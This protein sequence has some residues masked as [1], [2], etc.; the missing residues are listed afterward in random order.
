MIQSLNH[1]FPPQYLENLTL[2][3]RENMSTAE[4]TSDAY[5]FNHIKECCEMI[6]MNKR[7]YERRVITV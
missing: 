2:Y 4:D 7:D 3:L 1:D 6:K 5:S